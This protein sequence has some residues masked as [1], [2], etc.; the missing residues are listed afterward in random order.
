[1]LL[2]DKLFSGQEQRAYKRDKWT[3]RPV[4]EVILIVCHTLIS[5][6]H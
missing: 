2:L 1:M 5:I 4:L 3:V 6:N